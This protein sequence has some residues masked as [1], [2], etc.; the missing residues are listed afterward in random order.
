MLKR[1]LEQFLLDQENY[2]KKTQEKL[3]SIKIEKQ[4]L[5]VKDNQK[6]PTINEVKILIKDRIRKK[7]SKKKAKM[8]TTSTIDYTK[9]SKLTSLRK[10]KRITN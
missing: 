7:Y 4:K 8:M 9:E 5:E 3:N 1:N 2:V 6:N 10:E